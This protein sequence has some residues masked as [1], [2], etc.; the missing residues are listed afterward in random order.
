[1]AQSEAARKAD[2]KY[3]A[4]KT[5]RLTI[6]FYPADEDV[7]RHLQEQPSKQGY[8]KQLI[9]EDMQRHGQE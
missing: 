2:M 7:F 3:K 1:M 5:K 9:R 6:R 8:I 4:E